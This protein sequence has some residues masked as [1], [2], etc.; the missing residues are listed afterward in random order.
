[1]KLHLD[2]LQFGHTFTIGDLRVDDE[3]QCWTLEDRRR[4]LGVKVAHETCIQAGE[5]EVVVNFSQRFQKLMPLLVDVPMFSGV[6]IH[7]GNTS[8]DTEG[9]ILVG[10]VRLTSSI[11]G[12]RDA[13]SSLMVKINEAWGK[14]ERIVISITESGLNAP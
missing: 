5:Y 1:V 14:N 9:C 12:S 10:D 4:D 3:W 11:A 6:R 13:Y 7:P 8:E 2:R